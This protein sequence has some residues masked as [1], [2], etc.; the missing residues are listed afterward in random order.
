[1]KTVG[2]LLVSNTLE[3]SK[4]KK[5]SPKETMS[6]RRALKFATAGA[7]AIGATTLA[8]KPVVAATPTVAG[9]SIAATPGDQTAEIQ[10]ALDAAFDSSGESGLVRLE[11]GTFN[12]SSPLIVRTHV[13]LVGSGAGTRLRA[14]GGNFDWMIQLPANSHAASV[15]SLRMLGSN[16]AGGIEVLTSG[17]G[18]FSGSDSYALIENVIIHNVRTTGVRVGNGSDTRAIRLHNVVVRSANGGHGIEF[19]AV[20]SIISNCETAG[21]SLSGLAVLRANNRVSNHKSFFCDTNG[22]IVTGSRNQLSNCQSQ[23][24]EGDGFLIEDA[25]DVTL[26]SC[27]ADSNTSVGFRIRRCEGVTASGLLSFSRGGNSQ[28]TF[29]VRIQDS[30]MVHLS[31]VSRNNL[32]NFGTS[33]VINNIEDSGLLG[34]G[35]VVGDIDGDGD[36]DFEDIPGFIDLVLGDD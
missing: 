24:N 35:V 33:G 28:H 31:G 1:M 12:I 34:G 19:D 26:S 15:R 36:V 7:G 22:I 8:A 5:K 18:I 25:D 13:T 11:E 20:D 3:D 6:R 29:G 17:S 4:M 27:M 32:T 30:S 21:A 14:T 16:A 9:T 23:D 2:I 10:A